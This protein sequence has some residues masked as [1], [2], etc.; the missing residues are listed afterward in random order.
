MSDAINVV[1]KGLDM[2]RNIILVFISVLVLISVVSCGDKDN[3]NSEDEGKDSTPTS[4]VI[5]GDEKVSADLGEI[6]EKMLAADSSLPEMKTVSDKS[7]NAADLFAYLAEFD[8]EKVESYFFSYS[9]TGSAEE[10]A[11]V[12]LKDSSDAE[13]LKK[14]IEKHVKTRVSTFKEYDATQ[15]SLAQSAKISIL[16]DG[17][18]VSLITTKN[19]GA[20]EE[21]LKDLI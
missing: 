1:V 12:I 10:V 17:Q 14:A 19:S 7:D 20:V 18:M 11:V 21:V 15:V 8:Y 13:A 4:A 3:K 6:S 5:T 9:A 2:K 16:N